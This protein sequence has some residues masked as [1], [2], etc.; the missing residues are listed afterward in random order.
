MVRE[1]NGIL[2]L[3]NLDR[4]GGVPRTQFLNVRQVYAVLQH[5]WLGT[6]AAAPPAEPEGPP[7]ARCD[8][9][10]HRT[11]ACP[12]FSIPR[13]HSCA[14]WCRVGSLDQTARSIAESLHRVATG[15][16]PSER[17]H[18]ISNDCCAAAGLEQRTT[19]APPPL[20]LPL[21]L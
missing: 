8:S 6:L 15:C 1:A 21:L 4:L 19:L 13:T 3:G 11:A 7:C 9:R 16:A 10:H 18:I 5:W 12:H 14:D 17:L 2:G 20:L